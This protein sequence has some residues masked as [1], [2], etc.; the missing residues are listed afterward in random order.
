VVGKPGGLAW[1]L[2]IMGVL[3]TLRR[4]GLLPLVRC[5]AQRAAPL[6]WRVHP[7]QLASWAGLVDQG[8]G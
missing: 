6:C 8:W 3:M 4:P 2:N 7:V 1:G 5:W